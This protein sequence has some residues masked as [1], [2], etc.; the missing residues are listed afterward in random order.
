VAAIGAPAE[1]ILETARERKATLILLSSSQRSGFVRFLFGSV[2]EQVVR[3][4][5]IPVVVVPSVP[6]REPAGAF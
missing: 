1:S 5:P 2:A 3:R 6:E 4:S